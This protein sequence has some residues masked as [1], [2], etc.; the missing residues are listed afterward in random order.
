MTMKISPKGLEIIKQHEGFSATAYPDPGSK[1][2]LPWT[3]GY[4]HTATA[5]KGM[6]ITRAKAEELLKQDVRWAE[7]V[8]ERHIK[9]PLNQNQFDALTS[10]AFNVGEKQFKGSSVCKEAN[11]GNHA[12][13]PSRLALWIKNDG[14][15]MPG[16]VKRRGQEGE[17]YMT[18]EGDAPRGRKSNRLAQQERHPGKVRGKTI[19]ESRTS[20]AALGQM[21]GSA[22]VASSQAAEIKANVDSM[23]EGSSYDP[24]YIILGVICIVALVAGAWFF[25]DRYIKSEDDAA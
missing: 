9:V 24:A 6:R 20:M 12:K 19:T 18:P 2:G 7:R 8:V 17:L 23:L 16:L 3:I 15:V 25:Y 5:K 22:G 14:S 4:G 13:V 1:N 21:A 10:F 11:K